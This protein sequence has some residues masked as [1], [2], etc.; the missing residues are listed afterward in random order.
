MLRRWGHGEAKQA[1]ARGS[2]AVR[3]VLDSEAQH[4]SRWAVISS[5]A[6]KI[7]GDPTRRGRSVRWLRREGFVVARCTVE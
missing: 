2:R 6:S 1:F 7:G 4:E 3:L 5:V